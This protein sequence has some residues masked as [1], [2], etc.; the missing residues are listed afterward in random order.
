[1]SKP[2]REKRSHLVEYQEILLV[3]KSSAILP[4]ASEQNTLETGSSSE[5]SL[6]SSSGVPGK[7]GHFFLGEGYLG[8]RRGQEWRKPGGEKGAGEG[9]PRGEEGAGVGGTWG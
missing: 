2:G 1:M 3:T 8:V 7:F 4:N 6:G 5:L 9:V